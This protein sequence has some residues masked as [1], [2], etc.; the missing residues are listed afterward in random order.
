MPEAEASLTID[1]QDGICVVEFE[2]RK[3]LE[4]MVIN[5]IQEKLTN[6]I[7][8]ESPPR[9]LLNFRKVE[10]LSSAALGVLITISKLVAE[11]QGQL[12]LAN[13]HPQIFEVFKITRLN[14]LF[15]IQGTTDKALREFA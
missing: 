6:L 7:A 12:V 14:K 8:A 9:V 2:D 10:H 1:R 5:Q 11:R 13:I 4:E 15:N 3:I